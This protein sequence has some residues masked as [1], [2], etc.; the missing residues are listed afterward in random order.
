VARGMK[1]RATWS[2]FIALLAFAML[3]VMST[4]SELPPTV[5]SHFDAA[6]QANAF[7]SRSGY[8][9]FILCL[10]L[11]LPLGSDHCWWY[12]RVACTGWN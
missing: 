11:G 8:T 3:F 4:V 7:M 2:V 12:S 9:Q 6:G 5:A 1:H 10:T